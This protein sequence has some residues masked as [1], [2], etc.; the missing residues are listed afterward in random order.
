MPML[1]AENITKKIGSKTI[2]HGIDLHIRE[3]EFITVFGPNG[4]GKSTLLK[5]LSMLMKPSTGNLTINGFNARQDA[6][7]VR[8]QIGVISHQTFLYDN[9]TAYENLEFYGRMYGVDNLR[10]RIY[11]VLKEVGLEFSLNDPVRTFS[12]GMQQRLAIARA[13]IHQ[14]AILFLDEPYTGLDQQAIEILNSV[15]AGLNIKDRTVFMITHNFEQGLDLS[16][17]VLIV[18]KGRIAYE[19]KAR[20]LSPDE[21]KEIYL[22]TVGGKVQ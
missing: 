3:G 8:N 6:A 7:K 9:L 13:T 20:G 18:K 15:L 12:R 5:I 4:A 11:D 17:R 14:P 19:G 2:L 22:N 10:D 16:D 21:M 1:I